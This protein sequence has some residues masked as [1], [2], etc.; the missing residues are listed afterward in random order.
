LINKK[1]MKLN[2]ICLLVLVVLASA[3]EKK[4]KI[5]ITTGDV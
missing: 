5:K 1:E 3:G 4:S 2:L